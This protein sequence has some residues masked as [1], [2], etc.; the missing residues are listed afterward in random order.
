MVGTLLLFFIFWEAL[1]RKRRL[2]SINWKGV[3]L[4]ITQKWP[5]IIHGNLERPSIII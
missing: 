1:V 3:Y 5:T 2:I 4:D